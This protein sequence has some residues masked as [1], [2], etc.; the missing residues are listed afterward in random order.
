MVDFPASHFCFRGYPEKHILDNIIYKKAHQLH[1]ILVLWGACGFGIRI[2]G[3]PKNPNPQ[4][5]GNHRAPNHW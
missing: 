2:Q 4:E 1:G 5:S 3:T